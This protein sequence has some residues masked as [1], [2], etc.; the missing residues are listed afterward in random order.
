MRPVW[1]YVIAAGI[2]FVLFALLL[3][4]DIGSASA[5]KERICTGIKV[6]FEHQRNLNFL[7]AKDVK[8]Y[9]S[10]GYGSCTGKRLE[11]INLQE[12]EAM[13]DSKSAIKKSEVYTTK[14]GTLHVMIFQRKPVVR[15]MSSKGGWYADETG[16]MFPLQKNYTSRVLV[17]DGDIPVRPGDDFKGMPKNAKETKWMNDILAL[18]DYISGHKQWNEAI[19]Q[20]HLDNA[21][22]IVLVPRKGKEKFIFGRPEE[23]DKKF[24]K[25]ENYY[26]YIVPAKG[27]DFYSSVN[28]SFDGQIVCKK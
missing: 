9:V 20:I 12:I 13:L 8:D 1:K 26:K 15:F 25:I 18:V 5:R 27:E 10:K 14:D 7:S 16:Y 19:T 6:E 22:K 28:V 21:G 4:L 2:I 23:F 11:E 17:V 3:L 24:S